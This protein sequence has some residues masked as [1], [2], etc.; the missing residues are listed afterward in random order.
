MKNG[1]PKRVTRLWITGGTKTA[2]KVRLQKIGSIPAKARMRLSSPRQ[3]RIDPMAR[4]DDCPL[5]P[6]FTHA[7]KESVLSSSS[8]SESDSHPTMGGGNSGV[9][10]GGRIS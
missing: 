5:A 1:T 2:G 4:A 7:A 9:L 6:D 3:E 8:D 10:I